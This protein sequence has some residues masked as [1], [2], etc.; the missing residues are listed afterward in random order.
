ME[1]AKL[2]EGPP[3]TSHLRVSMVVMWRRLAALEA[4]ADN[5]AE[6]KIWSEQTR[7]ELNKCHVTP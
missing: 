1:N 5:P 2:R 7:R 6:I 4:L 3:Q